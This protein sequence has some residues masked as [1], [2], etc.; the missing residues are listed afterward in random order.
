[1]QR[2]VTA[3]ALATLQSA[4]FN[5]IQDN[6]L[7]IAQM[8][9]RWIG[10]A[11]DL[12]V[13]GSNNI[14]ISPHLGIVLNDKVLPAKTASYVTIASPAANTWYYVYA[15]DSAGTIAYEAV[16]T[17]PD[18]TYRMWKTGQTKNYRYVGCVRSTPGASQKL[19][20]SRYHNGRFFYDRSENFNSACTIL[21][22]G[23][24]T[25]TRTG[26]MLTDFLPPT[27]Y[28][29]AVDLR[30]SNAAIT[31][32]AQAQLYNASAGG[33]SVADVWADQSGT[34]ADARYGQ[35]HVPIFEC[36]VGVQRLWYVFNT[37]NASVTLEILAA[38]FID[39]VING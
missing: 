7:G 5:T 1:M 21:A 22:A 4:H 13:D 17:A 6:A 28:N 9:G 15:Y 37:S 12:K 27:V 32:A 16:T 35:V 20:R 38:G 14:L 25:T 34:A 2:V 3:S 10:D 11:P 23:A 26:V 30:L 8:N 31:G 33:N 19:V 36:E 24:G 39:S 18:A 29:I